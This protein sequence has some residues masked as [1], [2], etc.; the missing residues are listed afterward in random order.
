MW[1][2]WYFGYRVGDGRTVGHE[3]LVKSS[4]RR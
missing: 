3:T 1:G 4:D 2:A